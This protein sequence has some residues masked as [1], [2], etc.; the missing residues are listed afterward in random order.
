[1]LRRVDLLGYIIHTGLPYPSEDLDTFVFL[2]WFF[3]L[4]F[5]FFN[6]QVSPFPIRCSFFNPLKL[7]DTVT[8]RSTITYLFIVKVDDLFS[9]GFLFLFC[10]ISL[11][12]EALSSTLRWYLI[13]IYLLS[14]YQH[15]SLFAASFSLL[16]LMILVWFLY[17]A[18]WK[19]HLMSQ[20]QFYPLC[21]PLS[22]LVFSDFSS[23]KLQAWV[24][25]LCLP[26]RLHHLQL[27]KSTINISDPLWFFFPFLISLF[28][29][30]Y[31]GLQGEI[32]HF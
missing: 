27:H 2:G 10:H 13:P 16:V 28:L 21:L 32:C 14:L 20:F 15:L 6:S 18:P 22:K 5:P 17:H 3:W 25:Q 24:P 12:M 29:P 4:F 23:N 7:G 9:C 1:M 11:L 31:H 8:G 19:T 26:R 30:I